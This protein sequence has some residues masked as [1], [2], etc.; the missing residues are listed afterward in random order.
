[1]VKFAVKPLL[2]SLCSVYAKNVYMMI[3]ERKKQTEGKEKF[4]LN[5]KKRCSRNER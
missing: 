3:S 1:M 5:D 4:V 2:V